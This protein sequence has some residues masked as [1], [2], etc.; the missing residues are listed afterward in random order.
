MFLIKASS[1]QEFFLD[2]QGQ[3]E[4]EDLNIKHFV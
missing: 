1:T 2:L 4:S 3:I